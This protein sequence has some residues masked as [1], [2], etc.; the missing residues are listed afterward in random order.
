MQLG[1]GAFGSVF[2]ANHKQSDPNRP[3]RPWHRVA[4]KETSPNALDYRSGPLLTP[5]ELERNCQEVKALLRLQ[6]QPPR[7]GRD[8][9]VVCL[10]EYFWTHKG[11]N[12]ARNSPVG[13]LILVTEYL[14]LDLD[15]WW[16]Q[17]LLDGVLYESVA[18]EIA[19]T[20]VDALDFIHSRDV[21]HRDVKMP[22]VLFRRKGDY[23]SLKVIDFG[24]AKVLDHD[25]ALANDYCG[26][27]GYL[28]PEIY[29]N[30]PYGYE[31]D[32]FALGVIVFRL[33]SG[34]QPFESKNQ[35]KC[36]RDT[37]Q[38]RYKIMG[39]EW[40]E[41]P[42]EASRFVRKLLIGRDERLT[43]KQALDHEWFRSREESVLRIDNSTFDT[44]GAYTRAFVQTQAP[45]D[46]Q[47]VGPANR[48]W[49]DERLD[50]PVRYL[51]RHHLY[52]GRII[53]PN[54]D[55]QQQGD[56]MIL[57]E[58]VL[59]PHMRT[60][61][62][63]VVELTSYTERECRRICRQAAQIVKIMHSNSMAHRNIHFGQFV[64]DENVRLG[65]SSIGEARG[66]NTILTPILCL[67]GKGQAAR[68]GPLQCA[69]GGRR[70]AVDG[71]LWL[72]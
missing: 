34:N 39:N 49:L 65:F 28:A 54:N 37:I 13:E 42:P 36:H 20:L 23:R 48:F 9:P 15:Q 38:L 8:S 71:A 6:Q 27:P 45:V 67:N 17:Q 14:G 53:Q 1:D 18:R 11:G 29:S 56:N 50:R 26:T 59:Q 60:L 47:V 2:K 32:M 66:K 58:E 19:H 30:K 12:G 52:G 43:A 22:N 41:V 24:F 21:V 46:P 55:E 62:S 3:N 51:E 57:L 63:Y 35:D 7:Q 69:G 33:L 70:P 4:I 64:V 40:D 25:G 16:R 68:P 5:D 44:D 61:P 31:V 10:Y 72:H